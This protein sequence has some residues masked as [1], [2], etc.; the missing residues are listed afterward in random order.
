MANDQDKLQALRQEI[1]IIR[2]LAHRGVVEC[3][4]VISESDVRAS[5]PDLRGPC[6]VMRSADSDLK[7]FFD[8]H[9]VV[10]ESSSLL[11]VPAA[12][13]AGA[14]GRDGKCMVNRPRP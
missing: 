9:G 4:D 12:G 11:P 8:K 5:T 6:L 3:L 14:K 1:D 13:L 10:G 2:Q 7:H